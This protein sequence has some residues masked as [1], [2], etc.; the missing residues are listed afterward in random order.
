VRAAA[1]S[2]APAAQADDFLPPE[3]AFVLKAELRDARTVSL[4]WSMP[5]GYHL[6]RERLSF[7]GPG[8]A[9]PQLPA[10]QRKFDEN[11]GKEMETITT[12]WSCWCR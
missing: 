8:V 10:G 5:A 9:Q 7:T 6:Y 2:L 3:Q 1:G 11:F 12:R 4:R